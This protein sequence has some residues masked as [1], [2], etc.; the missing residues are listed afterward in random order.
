MPRSE[1]QYH[2][3]H[4]VRRKRAA[5]VQD[6]EQRETREI[7]DAPSV[8]FGQWCKKQRTHPKA[9]D[10][11]TDRQ[12]GRVKRSKVKVRSD[13]LR[14]NGEDCRGHGRECALEGDEGYV[15]PF[16]AGR[17]IERISRVFQVIPRL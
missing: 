9:K 13:T 4:D 10:V 15:D 12:V 16:S 5:N 1:S 17:P 14:A 11:H 7:H 6:C 2:Q 3:G 8:D